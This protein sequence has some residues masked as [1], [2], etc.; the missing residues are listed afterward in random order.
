M[1][2]KTTQ[3]SSQSDAYNL[4][5]DNF[6]IT[7]LNPEGKKFASVNRLAATGESFAVEMLLDYNS[8]LLR[9]DSGDRIGVCI[10]ET[11]DLA[12]GKD[13]GTWDQSGKNGEWNNA[14]RCVL[15]LCVWVCVCVLL[16]LLC[17]CVCVR[18]RRRVC[19]L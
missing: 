9:V 11:L 2:P 4:H 17:V 18:G 3:A 5:S 15:L 6:L 7:A 10:S 16:L 14:G 13:D 19:A 12:G 8:D 1:A